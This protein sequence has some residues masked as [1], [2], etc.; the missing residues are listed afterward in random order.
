MKK[1]IAGTGFMIMGG[2]LIL[3]ATLSA[4]ILSSG[5]TEWWSNLG[6]FGT[7]IIDNIPVIAM[8]GVGIV[9]VVIGA[10]Y[11]FSTALGGGASYGRFEEDEESEY[12]HQANVQQHEPRHYEQPTAR[13]GSVA[14]RE[15][16]PKE[17]E[18]FELGDLE[19]EQKPEDEE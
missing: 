17:F 3:A 13:R 15:F 16:K 12:P 9:F 7:A 8:L 18:E 2:L 11:A 5:I 10:V 6:K 1:V 14:R 19:I 4:A